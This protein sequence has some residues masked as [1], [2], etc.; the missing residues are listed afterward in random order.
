MYEAAADKTGTLI[1]A[2]SAAFYEIRIAKCLLYLSELLILKTKGVK[3]FASVGFINN[4]F[5]H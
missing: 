4:Y 1:K 3:L 2:R 5:L